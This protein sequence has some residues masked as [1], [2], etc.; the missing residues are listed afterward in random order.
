MRWI[1][2]RHNFEKLEKLDFL[3]FVEKRRWSIGES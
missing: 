2:A 1:D 3:K